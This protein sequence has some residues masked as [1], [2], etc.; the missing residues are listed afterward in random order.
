[1]SSKF[2]MLSA[3]GALTAWLFTC[4]CVC[5]CVCVCR[6]RVVKTLCD[7]FVVVYNN[8]SVMSTESERRIRAN[9]RVYNSK[10]KYAVSISTKIS[11][12]VLICM[13]RTAI[14][15]NVYIWQNYGV[16]HEKTCLIVLIRLSFFKKL[17]IF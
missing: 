13:L 5:V 11:L 6:Y 7:W 10:F 12:I 4:V 15:W 9:D 1:M 17:H 2:S 14:C 8:I 16:T 3:A